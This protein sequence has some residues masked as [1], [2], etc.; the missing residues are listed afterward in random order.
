MALV[1]IYKCTVAKSSELLCSNFNLLSSHVRVPVSPAGTLKFRIR[2][3]L[4]CR[5]CDW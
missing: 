5:K 4:R 3:G 1:L 2:H